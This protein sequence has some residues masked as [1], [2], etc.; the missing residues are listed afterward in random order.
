VRVI[1]PDEVYYVRIQPN[2]G[3]G[4]IHQQKGI[5][6]VSFQVTRLTDAELLQLLESNPARTADATAATKVSSSALRK[7]S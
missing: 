7:S 4:L 2:L 5:P 1:V 3:L 6:H